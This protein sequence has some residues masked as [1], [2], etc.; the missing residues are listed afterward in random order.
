[1]T[2]DLTLTK[3]QHT[4]DFRPDHVPVAT[5]PTGATIRFETGDIAYERLS[6]GEALDAIGLETFN[7]V[8]GPVYVEGAVPGDALRVEI[9]DVAIHRSWSVWLPGFGALGG[10]TQETVAK[11]IP[12]EDGV[13][14]ISD[15][16]RVPVDPMIGCIGLAP[17]SGVGST[18][19]PAS[20][21]GGNM[22]LRE[23]SPGTTVD[24]PVEVPGALLS[25]GDHHAAMG[26][27]EPTW[28]S[29]ESAG[30]STVRVTLLKD[31]PV[32]HPV[33]RRDRSIL[34]LGMG[35]DLATAHQ[36][37]VDR[38]WAWLVEDRGLEPFEAYAYASAR[39]EMRLGG[40]ASAMVLA[41]LP[42]DLS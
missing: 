27:G 38:A 1:M 31:S 18:F 23:M 10:Y 37:A 11:Q 30:A 22:D 2:P 5:V 40:P 26:R 6:R 17:A 14:V 13:A 32:S 24:L 9:L 29:L 15:R 3:A 33:L 16:L 36:H 20:H 25:V 41:V 35:D 28:V 21:W 39:L 7:R 4:V 12:L 42:E 34:F 8:T 19:M